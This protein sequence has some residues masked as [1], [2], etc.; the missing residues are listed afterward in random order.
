MLQHLDQ[1]PSFS[2][3]NLQILVLDE[4]DRCLDLGFSTAINSIVTSLPSPRQTLLFSATQTRSITDLARL[5]LT[6]PVLVSVHENSNS[7]TPDQLR[8]SYIVADV[9]HKINIL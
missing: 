8:Q 3:D 1:N 7:T 5:S 4:A 6:K 2:V 9:E